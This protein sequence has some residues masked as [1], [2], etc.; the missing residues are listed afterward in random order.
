MLEQS[1]SVEQIVSAFPKL[2]HTSSSW[3][4][5]Y[6]SNPSSS[7]TKQNSTISDHTS[8]SGNGA[9]SH[10]LGEDIVIYHVMCVIHVWF[11]IIEM[12]Q[13]EEKHFIK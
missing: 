3:S 10:E 8:A 2:S 11:S 1:Q 6:G 9:S 13:R 7:T 5:G 12:K 4:S